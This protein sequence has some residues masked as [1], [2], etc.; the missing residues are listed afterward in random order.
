MRIWRSTTYGRVYSQTAHQHAIHEDLLPFGDRVD[1]VHALR[2]AWDRR[3][4]GLKLHVGKAVV[5][6]KVGHR[7]AIAGD[8]GFAVGL[9][10]VQLSKRQHHVSARK[11]LDSPSRC[12][13]LTRVC[14][15]SSIL[16]TTAIWP[17]LPS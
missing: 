7:I 8:I 3:R 9:A 6:I 1:H 16:I 4:G 10:S 17:S 2:L 15:P 13:E 5:V 12:N 11:A 14:G